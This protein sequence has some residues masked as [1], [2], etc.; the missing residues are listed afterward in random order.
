LAGPERIE[1]SSRDLE[2][3]LPPWLGPVLLEEM[4]R[5]EL[6]A[7]IKG[8]LFSRQVVSSTHPHF[9][10]A[11]DTGFEPVARFPELQFSKLT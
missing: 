8:R 5:F 4:K 2:F 1:L 3:L 9:H 10:L 6:L 7:P 11:E